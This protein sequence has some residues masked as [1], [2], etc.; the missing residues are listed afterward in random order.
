M[1]TSQNPFPALHEYANFDQQTR[2]TPFPRNVRNYL[3]DV[4]GITG[5]AQFLSRDTLLK[6]TTLMEE[7]ARNEENRRAP[8]HRSFHRASGAN[9]YGI[10]KADTEVAI[11]MWHLIRTAA[12]NISSPPT[13]LETGETEMSRNNNHMNR[14]NNHMNLDG[15]G[16]DVR[17]ARAEF[18]N[19]DRNEMIALLHHAKGAQFVGIAN[20]CTD[21]SRGSWNCIAKAIGLDLSEG[22]TVLCSSGRGKGLFVGIVSSVLPEAPTSAEYDYRQSMQH[23]IQRVDEDRLDALRKL[24]KELLQRITASEAQ[25]RLSRLTAQLGLTLDDISLALPA[26]DGTVIDDTDTGAE[27]DGT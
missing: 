22:E 1:K 6:L 11:R 3:R 8:L 4:T 19:A 7:T 27:A 17:D 21:G 24:D 14:N 9:P 12:E 5:M 2:R 23:V 13:Q 15:D 20:R 18:M 10:S 16:D 26:V 25:D